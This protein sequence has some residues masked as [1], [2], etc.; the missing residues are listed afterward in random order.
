ML[1]AL[2]YAKNNM[3]LPDTAERFAIASLHRNENINIQKNFD[4]LMR[5]VIEAS[6]KAHIKFILHPV[7]KRKLDDSA[8]KQ[9][10]LSSDIELLERMDYVAFTS[11]MLQAEFLITDGGSNQEEASY[12]GLPCLIM[13]KSTER[14]EGLGENAVLSLLEEETVTEF[15]DNYQDYRKPMR[16]P[17]EASVAKAIID[18]IIT[19]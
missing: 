15:L 9:K 5:T 17:D 16:A 8:W 11:L 1:D 6:N 7:T 10:L 4:L 14:V 13:R 18:F 12:M 19:I 3:D 2:V